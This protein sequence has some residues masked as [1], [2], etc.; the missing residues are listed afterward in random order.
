M[1]NLYKNIFGFCCIIILSALLNPA[2]IFPSDKDTTNAINFDK[3]FKSK[4]G[5]EVLAKVGNKKITVK[6]FIAGYEFGPA[7]YKKEK[8]S[9]E[10]YLK[11][12]L[13][14]K[15]L[16]LEGYAQGYNDSTRVKKLYKAIQSD[17]ATEQLFK[18]DIQKEVNVPKS[19][20][21]QA[22]KDKQ[23]TYNIKWLY[24][25]NSDSLSFFVSGLSNHIGFDSLYK[26]QLNDSVFYDQ[27]SMKMDKFK[28]SIRNPQLSKVVDTLKVNEISSPIKAPDGWYIVMITDIWKNEIVNETEYQK[29]EYDARTALEMQQMDSLSDS[30]VHNMMISHNPIIQARP[31]DLLRSY[32]GS[33]VLADKVYK[34]WRLDQRLKNEI[35][36]YDSLSDENLSK[37][38]L[39]VLNDTSFTMADFI[40]WFRLRDEY[41]KFNQTNFNSFSAS[42][43]SMIWQMVRDNLLM[44]RAYSRGLE[45]I[46]IVQEES[47][48]WKDKIVYSIMR[49]KIATSVGLNIESPAQRMKIY[50]KEKDIIDKTNKVLDEL[51]TKYKISINE[52]LLNIISVQDED[53]PHAIDVY[54][55][56]KGGIFPHPA[57]PSI[58]FNWREWH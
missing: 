31:F 1:K 37:I 56:K 24:A 9:K 4:I 30:Y 21:Q 3:A 7:F 26:M 42:L 2:Y 49:D 46:P 10:I 51:K 16:A 28:L 48:W 58:D 11:Y 33:Y 36:N 40:N 44:R 6:E 18:R 15:L 39:V 34:E 54:V 14:E 41:L 5:D 47:S 25:P 22:V 45:N 52:K 13:D 23:L 38:P 55:V 50:N 12:L 17:L 19:K 29:D 43:E 32:M 27:R 20:I 35:Q 57:F 8:D 53:N